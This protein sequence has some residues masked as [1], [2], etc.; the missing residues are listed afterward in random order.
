MGSM[1]NSEQHPIF[2]LAFARTSMKTIGFFINTTKPETFEIVPTTIA[3]LRKHGIQS[4]IPSDEA[5]IIGVDQ[6]SDDAVSLSSQTS[7]ILPI[8]PEGVPTS[9][10]D[11]DVSSSRARADIVSL[12]DLILVLGGDGTLL[13]AVHTPGIETVPILAV[14]VGH[15]GFLTDVARDE[16]YPAL[17]RILA[18]Q[19]EVDSRMMLEVILPNGE[20][21]HALNDVVIRH[22]MRLIHLETQINRQPCINYTADGLIVST[23]SGSTGYS[24]S[25]GGSIAEP[26]LNAIL[27]TPISPHDL[28]VRP[29]ITHGDSEIQIAIQAE[30]TIADE[31]AGTLLVDGQREVYSVQ[32]NI[33]IRI[34]KAEKTIQLIRS[35][36]R[37]YY[38]VL[39]EK[40]MFG[41]GV[42]RKVSVGD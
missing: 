9:L 39:R 42:N 1:S 31:S 7:D 5:K 32:P 20:K 12:S 38:E 40:L 28:T 19:Y 23:P 26:H 8:E 3:W 34:R 10:T 33:P 37:S 15:L 25:C 18:G 22:H 27:I 2:L 14:N 16:L 11:L 4:L 41:Q 24:L 17:S 30:E 21:R 35:Q 36:G 6:A 13:N 29:F